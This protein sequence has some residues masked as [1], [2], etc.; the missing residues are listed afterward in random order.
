MAQRALVMI[1][2]VDPNADESK[3]AI[4]QL[5]AGFVANG[6]YNMKSL[7]AKSALLCRGK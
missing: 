3:A 4:N 2:D 1:C 7:F 6:N 5:A